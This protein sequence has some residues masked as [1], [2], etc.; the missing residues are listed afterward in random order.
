MARILQTTTHTTRTLGQ[1]DYGRLLF[2]AMQYAVVG[3]IGLFI[4]LAIVNTVLGASG[5]APAYSPYDSL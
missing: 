2:L 1:I 3:G 5:A 4:V